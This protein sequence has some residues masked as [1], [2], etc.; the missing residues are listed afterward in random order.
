MSTY[1]RPLRPIGMADL[2]DGR[3]EKFGVREHRNDET[4]D[5]HRMLTD[6][7]N[8]LHV[9]VHDDCPEAGVTFKRYF[10]NGSPIDILWAI[11][12]AFNVEIVSEHQPQYWGFDTQEEWDAAWEAVEAAEKAKLKASQ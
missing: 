3:L 10:P 8:Y 6:G 4:D 1:Y 5:R 12:D 11:Q 9:F 2:F 7:N